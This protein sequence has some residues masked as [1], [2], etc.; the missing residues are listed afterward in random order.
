M[1]RIILPVICL[2]LASCMTVPWGSST[3]TV[4]EQ[5]KLLKAQG[6][7][8]CVVVKVVGTYPGFVTGTAIVVEAYDTTNG[9]A[10]GDAAIKQTKLNF[11]DCMEAVKPELQ[12]FL[13]AQ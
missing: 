4:P 6:G 5:V 9:V 3:Y 13:S 1:K 10:G 7:S 11:T 8:G 12:R 2:I